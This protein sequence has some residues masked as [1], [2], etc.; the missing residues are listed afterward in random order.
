MTE[1]EEIQLKQAVTNIFAELTLLKFD[2]HEKKILELCSE[3]YEH[4]RKFLTEMD[5]MAI[6]ELAKSKKDEKSND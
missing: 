1:T 4:I 5:E 3:E 2:L 6:A